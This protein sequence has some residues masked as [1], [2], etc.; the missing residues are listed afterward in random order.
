MGEGAKHS[1]CIQTK[2]LVV[3]RVPLFPPSPILIGLIRSSKNTFIEELICTSHDVM[4]GIAVN[5]KEITSVR[6]IWM[7]ESLRVSSKRASTLK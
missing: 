4:C 6:I 2:A 5:R 7:L 1:S 3:G